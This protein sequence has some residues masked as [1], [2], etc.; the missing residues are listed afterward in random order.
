MDRGHAIQVGGV[1]ERIGLTARERFTAQHAPVC[2]PHTPCPFYSLP[3][4]IYITLTPK[5]T[6]Y[7]EEGNININRKR[8]EWTGSVR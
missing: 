7:I 8:V 3:I 2:S 6:I 5:I 4:Y 1:E